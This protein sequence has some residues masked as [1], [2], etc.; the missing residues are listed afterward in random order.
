MDN[1]KHKVFFGNSNNMKEVLDSSVNII[2]TS[3][4]YPMIEMWDKQFSSLNPKIGEALKD[5]KG[6]EAYDLMNEE[7]Y[8]VWKEVNRVLA[9]GGIVCI[10]IGDATRKVNG[11]FHLYAN[12]S[13]ITQYFEKMGFQSLPLIIWRK[14]TNK[15]NKYMGSGMLPPSAYVTLEHEYILIFRKGNNREFKSNE[16]LKRQESSFFWEERNV[17]F[18]DLWNGLKGVSQSLNHSDLRERSAAYPFELAYRLINMYSLNGDTVL[19]PFFGTGTTMLAAMVAGRN[20]IG[21][22]IDPNFKKVIDMRISETIHFGRNIVIDRLK[23]HKQYIEQREAEKGE[24][25]HYSE[26]YEFKI[27]TNQEKN[28]FLPLIKD[29]KKINDN[30]LEA[31]YDTEKIELGKKEH[32]AVLSNHINK[33]KVEKEAHTLSAYLL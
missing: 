16:I 8:K 18:S 30:H 9:D 25:K 31:I 12:H 17:W 14:E 26:R 22:E 11:S 1:T 2:V 15:P 24:P 10:N 20:S 28:M 29:I 5:G 21:Y 32:S 6:M 3:P 7:L 4:P 19:D 27:V 13:R 23:K 33:V